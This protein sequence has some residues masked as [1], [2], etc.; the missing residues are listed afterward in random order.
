MKG[1]DFECLSATSK[2]I[3]RHLH[4]PQQHIKFGGVA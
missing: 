4:I 3:A 2:V 1:D